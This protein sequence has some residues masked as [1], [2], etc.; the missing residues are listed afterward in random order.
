MALGDTD[1]QSKDQVNE[2]AE[3]DET[4]LGPSCSKNPRSSISAKQE[5]AKPT[6]SS[7]DSRPRSSSQGLLGRVIQS[8]TM[9]NV[10][11]SDDDREPMIA[12]I[13]VMPDGHAVVCDQANHAV[14]LLDSTW[15]LTDHLPVEAFPSDIA[16]VDNNT[17]IVSSM[18]YLQFVH[19]LPH[20]KAGRKM[21]QFK[22]SRGVVVF[23][24]EIYVLCYLPCQGEIRV[25]D[26]KLNLKRRLGYNEDDNSFLFNDPQALAINASGE[27]L[28]VSNRQT[29][30]CITSMDGQVVFKYDH[31]EGIS[32][33]YCDSGDNILY[34]SRSH[35]EVITA[36]GKEKCTLLS[37]EDL[38]DVPNSRCKATSIGY[39][40][41]DGTLVIGCWN[42]E[43]VFLFKLTN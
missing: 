12:G 36:D 25:L 16:A 31:F 19:V 6:T 15:T 9:V 42:F 38:S 24:E 3:S 27:R 4:G 34:C 41:C 23:G 17:V 5:S 14:K 7:D 11:H 30:T 21:Q 2:K 33:L 40:D 18:K 28:F 32:G 26:I 8:R 35:V 10:K 22:W 39:R 43:H 37:D 13:A 1:I 20:L 29:V